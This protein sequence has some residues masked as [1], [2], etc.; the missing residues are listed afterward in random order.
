MI[1]TT[2]YLAQTLST[3]KRGSQP[4]RFLDLDLVW[5]PTHVLDGFHMIV[6]FLS[7]SPLWGGL[8]H[9]YNRGHNVDLHVQRHQKI[10]WEIILTFS[11]RPSWSPP[12][13]G[14]N[15]SDTTLESS[16]SRIVILFKVFFFSGRLMLCDGLHP[17]WNGISFNWSFKQGLELELHHN[18]I[19]KLS[20]RNYIISSHEGCRQLWD[21]SYL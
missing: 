6:L 16:I 14:F 17:R 1:L 18:E 5:L 20:Q 10:K 3:E 9:L 2:W 4:C 7:L 8:S 11:C 12:S 19:V 13:G 21:I 15:W